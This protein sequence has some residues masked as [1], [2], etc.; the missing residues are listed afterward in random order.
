M[1]NP[2]NITNSTLTTQTSFQ[3]DLTNNCV[4]EVSP[5]RWFYVSI[6]ESG[7]TFKQESESPTAFLEV[8]KNSAI[9]WIDYITDDMSKDLPQIA[10]QIGFSENFVTYLS[11]GNQLNYE[12]FDDE[13]LMRLPSI[14]IRGNDV[15]AYPLM[16]MIKKNTVFTVHVRL[17][18]K[19]FIRLRRYSET[20]LRRIPLDID[21]KEKL[22]IL[23]S[24]IIDSN[25]DSNFRHLR[26]IEEFGDE[27]NKDLMDPHTD[28]SKLG[29]KIY[30]MKHA[31]IIYMDALWESVDVLHAIRYGDAVLL[32]D[33][34]KILNQ[35]SI[36]VE[37]VNSQLGLS[38]H[39]SEVLSSGIEATQTIY[40]NQL[41]I[42][43]NQLT[44]LNNRFAQLA[45][46]LAIL[47]TVVMIPNT[48]ATV[49]GNSVWQYGPEGLWWYLLIMIGAT[50]SGCIIMWYWI[51]KQ[52]LVPYQKQ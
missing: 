17:V 12:D 8:T 11:S 30:E 48:I 40:N 39:M 42:A 19:R 34:E 46:Y 43:N 16:I 41:T 23:L 25:N 52:K 7:K 47:A 36:M 24:R 10:A 3:K 13:L 50:G 45:A 1:N 27:L 20:I 35:V 32:S 44:I 51:H 38:E 26:V 9:A 15:K 33:N 37:Q 2:E 14:Q 4:L 28:K 6:N 29:P 22:T 18:D 5:K 31:L 49:L 21:I